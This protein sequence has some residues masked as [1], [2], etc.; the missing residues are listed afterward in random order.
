VPDHL[1][2]AAIPVKGTMGGIAPGA[3][4]EVEEMVPVLVTLGTIVPDAVWVY[5]FP[6]EVL[7]FGKDTSIL[8]DHI[9]ILTLVENVN[10]YDPERV[11]IRVR[12]TEN[13]RDTVYK[14]NNDNF[15]NQVSNLCN[16]TMCHAWMRD[17]YDPSAQ[18]E[19]EISMASTVLEGDHHSQASTV[20]MEDWL[21]AND[22]RIAAHHAAE[23][24]RWSATQ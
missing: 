13:M 3:T 10:F 16:R 1:W 17:Y 21:N 7:P 19:D 2:K 9:T 14:F 18:S 24:Q 20:C 12:T 23:R 6:M 15:S 8:L 4:V 11:K 22:A 5:M